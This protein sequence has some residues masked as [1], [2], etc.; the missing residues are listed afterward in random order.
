MHLGGAADVS[1]PAVNQAVNVDGSA[2]LGQAAAR[3]GVRRV[4]LFSSHCA[5]RPMQD[6][7]GRTKLASEEAMAASGV[8]LVVFRPTMIYGEG[9][10]EFTTF[11]RAVRRLPLVPIVGDGAATIRPVFLDDVLPAIVEALRRPVAGSTFEICGP[12]PVSFDQLVALIAGHLGRWRRPLHV[13]GSL[14]LLGARLLGRLLRHPPIT[15][16]QV[17]GFLQHTVA[18]EGPAAS[19]L[20]FAP[21]AVEDGLAALFA[22]TPVRQW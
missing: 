13:P 10:K 11:V 4:V 8:P 21:R 20:G 5:V 12:G 22:R 16:D 17:M 15:V 14:A 1:D 19:A 18:D 6:A 3:A 9:S 7:Y 2:A